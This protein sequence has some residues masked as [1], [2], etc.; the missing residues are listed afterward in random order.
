MT[1]KSVGLSNL[2]DD[3]FALNA[4]SSEEGDPILSCT[5]KTEFVT[6][7]VQRTN[8]SCS[9]KIGP[10]VQY[11]KKKDKQAQIT[12]KKDESVR[13]DDVYKSH[14]VSV[15]SGEPAGSV[16]KPPAK[17][18]PGVAKPISGGRLLKRGGGPLSGASRAKPQARALPGAGAGAG[19]GMAPSAP[20]SAGR[21]APPPPSRAPAPPPPA[22][23][24]VD[25]YKVL[26]DFA[27]DQAGEVAL[28]KGEL[29]EVAS[30]DDGGW[31]LVK[32]GANEGW[33]PSNYLELV[34]AAKPAPPPPAPVRRAPPAAPLAPAAPATPRA[35]LAP[36]I[37]A[38]PRAPTA[39]GSA[40]TFSVPTPKVAPTSNHSF[41]AADPNAQP[42]SVFGG[43]APG[44]LAAI[45]AAKRAA[46]SGEPSP[47]PSPSGGAS[48]NGSRPG[49]ALGKPALAPKP[50]AKPPT[51]APKPGAKP[52]IPGRAPAPPA[53]GRPG[54]PAAPA[55]PGAPPAPPRVGGGGA[56]PPPGRPPVPAAATRVPA[57]PARPNGVGK[58]SSG[59]P[60]K[61]GGGEARPPNA[62]D[63]QAAIRARG[64]PVP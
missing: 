16:S 47:V 44:G 10:T 41:I 55:R 24:A 40:K 4:G 54:A 43:G 3:W 14:V 61:L 19:A 45:L 13:K 57:A 46:A 1:I 26:F 60:V 58:V 32:K 12:F 34:P 33:A 48:P 2:R 7:L 5:F 52:P 15:A 42:V 8:G 35:P 37:P 18:K 28:T 39:P 11:A 59:A 21:A 62:S 53:P 64:R 17:R 22:A 31:W 56:P 63:L 6:H 38:A 50:A 25:Q 29:V 23:P 9:V 30:K 20:I 27:T 51:L 49:S 36:S